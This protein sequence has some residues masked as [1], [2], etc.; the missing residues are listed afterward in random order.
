MMSKTVSYPKS[1]KASSI[2]L[3]SSIVL[4]DCILFFA[5]AFLFEF[6]EGSVGSATFVVIVKKES[7]RKSKT[8][9]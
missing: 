6:V 3:A 7:F 4:S 8:I 5:C 1:H 9:F 2:C